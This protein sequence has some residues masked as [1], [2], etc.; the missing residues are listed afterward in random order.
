V[1]SEPWTCSS[2]KRCQTCAIAT[3]LARASSVD[4]MRHGQA[5][6][7]EASVP[8]RFASCHCHHP[9]SHLPWQA[10]EPSRPLKDR[11]S[12]SALVFGR[13]GGHHALNG[14]VDL[15]EDEGTGV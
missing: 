2:A 11:A 9:I 13:V 7:C 4:C 6:L 14:L 5:L 15:F 1:K 8:F 3:K 10:N 12:H